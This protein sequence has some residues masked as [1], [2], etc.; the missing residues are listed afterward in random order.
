[1]ICNRIIV[2][3]VFISFNSFG[4]SDGDNFSLEMQIKSICQKKFKDFHKAHMYFFSRHVDSSFF[5]SS[6]AY[7]KISETSEALPYL[8]YMY[9]VNAIDKKFF[10]LADKKLKQIPGDFEYQY[11]VHYNR[12]NIALNRKHYNKALTY[13]TLSLNSN[14]VQSN[15]R[16]K[17]IYH[18][19]GVCHLHLK[20]YDAS[21][22]F[23]L[24]ELN[25]SQKEKDTLSTI[26]SKLDLAN[27]FYEQ[28]KDDIAIKYFKEAY[29]LAALFS[30]IRAKQ[31]TSEN[32]AIV[33][34]NRKHYEESTFY[35]AEYVKWKDSIWNRDKISQLLEKD[36]EIALLTKNKEIAIQKE[37]ALKQK[38]R[39]QLF[40]MLLFIIMLFL[41][42]LFYL[43]RIK[44]KQNTV[45]KAQKEQ[46]EHLN[47]TK[48][49]LL[50]IISH[51]LRTPIHTLKTNIKKLTDLL[52]NDLI[53]EAIQLNYKNVGISE[54]TS[55]ILNNILNWALQQNDQLLFIPETHFINL[56]ILPI[57]KD[58]ESIAEAKNIRITTRFEDSE[59]PVILD[60][61]L[62]KIAIRNL[63]DNAIKYTPGGGSIEVKT[64]FK[65]AG[66][67]LTL[68]DS[69]QGMPPDILNMINNYDILTIEKIDRSKGLGLGLVLSK[70]LI[71]K[72]KGT[73]EIKNNT[74]KGIT[75]T[76]KLP[77]K[78]V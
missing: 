28:Y 38:E 56:L 46:L 2:F 53:Q 51:D 76:M 33:E 19:I 63:I 31:I 59:N 66:C 45:I 72:N 75:I 37:I 48:N 65:A 70:T 36:K 16:L 60:K 10:S 74:N 58:F 27:L 54:S 61:E 68:K 1:M 57:L 29:E 47:A 67:E 20:N 15:D 5:Y 32:L 78:D 69:G 3:L 21:E 13:Y 44:I 49:Y 43:Y 8:N 52:N 41:G 64:S 40:V 50:S 26:Y 77:I 22:K 18:N 35:Y 73:F 42:V 17:R 6:Q 11:L 9:G 25:I 4:Q 23:L 14:K 24:K 39:I 7:N 34:K 55:G 12:G 30:D 71:L 62:F